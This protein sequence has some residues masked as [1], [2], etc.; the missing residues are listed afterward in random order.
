MTAKPRDLQI[1]RLLA[2]VWIIERAFR[3][4]FFQRAIVQHVVE[5]HGNAQR[6]D[7][8]GIG[9]FIF[10]RESE[11]QLSAIQ[12][13]VARD[14]K[15][16]VGRQ[17]GSKVGGRQ[18]VRRRRHRIHGFAGGGSRVILPGSRIA[19]TQ[20][21]LEVAQVIVAIL[22]SIIEQVARRE[23][24][25]ICAF[26]FEGRDGLRRTHQAQGKVRSV[27]IDRSLIEH[28]PFFLGRASQIRS[29]NQHQGQQ[30]Q[31]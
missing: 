27:K 19:G 12:D 30:T 4:G 21:Q 16:E 17:G 13:P 31:E 24:E 10:Q 14:L 23:I 9:R 5:D 6:P 20:P 26:G 29:R 22:G 2:D 3:V 25:S 8:D 28:Q 11:N 18:P 7:L 1:S 15:R